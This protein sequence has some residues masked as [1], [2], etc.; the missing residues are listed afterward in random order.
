MAT[1]TN[2]FFF[3]VPSDRWSFTD[4]EDLLPVIVRLMGERNRRLLVFGRRRMGKTSLIRMAGEK[5]KGAF[6]YCDISTASDLNEVAKKLLS[7]APQETDVRLSSALALA[8]KYLKSVG[9]TAGKVVI[10]GELRQ[11]EGAVTLESVLNLLNERACQSDALW[12]ICLDEFQDI[13]TLAGDRIDWKLRG[14]MQEHRNLNYIFTGSDHRIVEWMTE[15]TA[16]FFKQLQQM[17]VGPIP[18]GI[19]SQWIADRA[20]MGGLPDFPYAEKIVEA[21]GPCTGDIIRLAKT[22]FDLARAGV[23]GPSAIPQAFDS[24]ALGELN[25]EFTNSWRPLMATQRAILRAIASGR[26]PTA[27]ATL[28]EFGIKAASTASTALE[29]LIMRQILVRDSSGVFFDNPYFR[30]WVE[31]NGP[32]K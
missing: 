7:A 30:R 8:A 11:D 2:P 14:I 20:K 21:G 32:V 10:S 26:P 25:A 1:L 31:F 24:I 6:L 18:A 28:R 5:A 17:E 3:E 19:M 16:P 13:R 12:T 22:V 4:R 15:P 9:V 23:N 29:H 27:S